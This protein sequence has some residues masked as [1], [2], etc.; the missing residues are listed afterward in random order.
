MIRP[1]YGTK[2]KYT[3]KISS[4]LAT[5]LVILQS[6]FDKLNVPFKTYT[7]KSLHTLSLT[8]PG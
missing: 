2:Y 3:D 7:S 4:A 5:K 8:C 1:S 6:K